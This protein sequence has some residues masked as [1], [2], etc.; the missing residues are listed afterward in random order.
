L[1]LATGAFLERGIAA[2]H[3]HSILSFFPQPVS[4]HPLHYLFFT[5]PAV[6]AAFAMPDFAGTDDL[7]V[8][9][10]PVFAR[11][12]LPTV[13]VVVAPDRPDWTYQAGQAAK[14]TIRVL[15]DNV[16]LASAEV[17]VAIGPEQM[18]AV[19]KKNALAVPAAGL[20]LD[21][22]TMTDPGFMRCVA[23]TRIGGRTYRGVATAAFSPEK[24]QPTQAD[25]EDFDVFWDAAK[26]ELARIPIDPTRVL[27]PEH[28]TNNVNV[29]QVSFRV[30]GSES[31]AY[32]KD[33][34]IFG[35]LCE[36]TAPGK[37]PALL[38]PPGAGARSYIPYIAADRELAARGMIT[39]T[40][41]IHGIPVNLHPD[42]YDQMRP[43]ALKNYWAYNMDDRETYYFRRV[44][45]GCVRA[46][47][48]LCALPNHDGQNLLVTGLSQG[49]QLTVVTA[50]LDPRV[51]ALAAVYPAYCDVTGYLHGRAGGWPHMF[52]PDPETGAKS[53]HARSP[54]KI[55]T[56]AYY[57]A[58]NFA[59]RIKAPGLYTWGY[60]DT[61]CPPTS[62]FAAYN[63]ITAP[64]QLNLA[65]V[66]GHNLIAEETAAI[67]EWLLRQAGMRK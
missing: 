60:N 13:Q 23:T 19:I 50:G 52:C 44:Y 6:A 40:I 61:I 55:A 8:G 36:P 56:T 58:V 30:T 41:G 53:V 10:V 26:A 49:G 67:N 14:F 63:V 65:L 22:G 24:I 34:R 33:S 38:R 25:P 17:S 47:D 62:M 31:P 21:G 35:I 28:C 54:A 2:G 7:P 32:N 51:T 11:T 27:L 15:A 20:T 46:N 43:A 66:T 57:D 29:Y 42:I 59:R 48:Y 9:P 37:Y 3:F 12:H 1:V 5:V 39:L 45:L 4:M 16:P 18:P 64:K